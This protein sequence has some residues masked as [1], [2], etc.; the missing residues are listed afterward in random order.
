MKKAKR[1][2]GLRLLSLLLWFAYSQQLL[3]GIEDAFFTVRIE[4][5]PNK[6]SSK[7]AGTTAFY[8]YQNATEADITAIVQQFCAIRECD[9]GE[10]AWL[11]AYCWMG[12]QLL[13]WHITQAQIPK[14]PLKYWHQLPL[15]FKY[16][17]WV[18]RDPTIARERAHF[19]EEMRHLYKGQ[20]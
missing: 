5:T 10:R 9:F 8:I 11:L 19:I 20:L 2:I 14:L 13:E 4:L 3:Q 15:R 18:E 17:R 7:A 12:S 16:P 1:H 6:P